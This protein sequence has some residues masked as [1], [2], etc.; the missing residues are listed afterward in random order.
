MANKDKEQFDSV[1]GT[2][3]IANELSEAFCPRGSRYP[4]PY[5]DQKKSEPF[6]YRDLT[7]LFIVSGERPLLESFTTLVTKRCPGSGA[8]VIDAHTGQ[9]NLYQGDPMGTGSFFAGGHRIG[10]SSV[11]GAH[12]GS[13]AILKAI[14]NCAT[15]TL[16]ILSGD[17][18]HPAERIQGIVS[19]LKKEREMVLC[20]PFGSAHGGLVSE[21]ACTRWE[22]FLA[23]WKLRRKGFDISDPFSSFF[24]GETCVLQD[25]A[26]RLLQ[27]ATLPPL[28]RLLYEMLLLAKPRLS[29]S[30][31]HYAPY[32]SPALLSERHTQL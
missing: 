9:T 18:H 11:H 10:T 2:P 13:R 15:R 25:I 31:I 6:D 21:Y 14:T 17:S 16:I 7:I 28:H 20:A 12:S 27:Q 5:E 3:S 22:L 29:F 26:K 8:L 32:Y 23:R 1:L 4:V 19:E 30:Q 24:G